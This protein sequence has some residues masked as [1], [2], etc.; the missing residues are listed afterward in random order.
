M[1]EVNVDVEIAAPI[2]AV[3]KTIR[4]IEDYP[5]YMEN[6]RAVRVISDEGSTRTSEWSTLLKGSVLEWTEE[7]HIDAF[8]H[9]ITFNQ[10]D[11]DLDLFAGHWQ[12][13]TLSPTSTR[14]TLFVSFEIGIPLLA[15][16]LNPVAVRALRENSQHML[17]GIEERV[18]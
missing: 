5:R 2:D 17:R 8:D 7:E 10:L 13:E 4:E 16:M 12:L 14:A 1:P 3:W 18:A 9:R 15:D 11:G 6:V